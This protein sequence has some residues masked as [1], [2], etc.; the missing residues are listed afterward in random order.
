MPVSHQSYE[1]LPLEDPEGAWELW[2]RARET[3]DDG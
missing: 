1:R 3:D 2:S